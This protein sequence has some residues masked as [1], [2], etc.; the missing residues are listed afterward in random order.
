[1]LWVDKHRPTALDKLDFHADLS[2][3]LKKMAATGDF[4]HTLFYGPSG[5]GKKTRVLALLRELFGATVEK[6][7]VETRS[8]KTPSGKTLEI[9]TL[10]S[11]YHIEINPSDAGTQ[12]RLVVQELI[13][14]FASN[15][16]V[17]AGPKGF[18]VVIL[19]EVERLSKQAQHALRRT[20]EKHTAACRLILCCTSLGRVIP[21]VRSRCLVIRVPAPTHAEIEAVLTAVCRKES[22]HLPAN[23]AAAVA[24]QSGRN[25][26]RALLMLEAS[27]VQQYPFE[28]RHLVVHHAWEKFIKALADKITKEQS[29]K[30]LLEVRSDLYELLTRCIPPEVIIKQL[31][32]QLSGICDDMLKHEVYAWAAFYEHRMQTG[33]KA[34]FHLEAF[35]ARFMALYKRF[36][37]NMNA[38]FDD[39]DW[40]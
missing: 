36:L 12:D 19:N 11:N 27:K 3:N 20:M 22:V 26:R 14:E 8:F 13:K 18:K 5:A 23:I 16:P 15:N 37:V 2:Q 7:K 32:S 35:V 29:P 33:S 9:S 25:L 24:Q 39:M 17:D 4:P 38:E 21:A 28:E 6:L 1:M 31:A 30:R 10:A 40:Q 34:I